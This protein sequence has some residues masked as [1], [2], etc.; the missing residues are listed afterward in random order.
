MSRA[1]VIS[2]EQLERDNLIGAWAFLALPN[3]KFYFLPIIKSCVTATTL[4]FRVMYEQIFAAIFRRN[5]S[6]TLVCVEPLDCTFTHV[7]FSIV[8][9]K[10]YEIPTPV[11]RLGIEAV[12][13]SCLG[14]YVPL[15]TGVSPVFATGG[16]PV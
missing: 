16:C 6:K 8:L 9:V 12:I 7:V 1:G 10:D 14:S 5:K 13:L 2:A 3:F 4:N 11:H 15:S